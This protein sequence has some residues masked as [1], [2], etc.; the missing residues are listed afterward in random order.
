MTVPNIETRPEVILRGK[1]ENELISLSVDALVKT[2]P[3]ATQGQS[4]YIPV[5][6]HDDE[7]RTPQK[8]LLELFALIISE[9][10]G[11]EPTIGL[12]CHNK[13]KPTTIRL[14]PGLRI[15]RNH[16]VRAAGLIGERRDRTSAS[17][18]QAAFWVVGACRVDV[19]IDDLEAALALGVAV[20]GVP[21]P[22]AE[23]NVADFGEEK[24]FPVA[25]QRQARLAFAT[26]LIG[27]R[28][29]LPLGVAE[30]DGTELARVPVV[31]AEDLFAV[32][33]CLDKQFVGG[34]W[35]GR[36][37][38]T[39]R[40]PMI[41]DTRAD[42]MPWSETAI[43][44]V[45]GGDLIRRP[46]PMPGQELIEPGCRM[47]SDAGEHVGEPGLRVDAVELGGGDQGVDR[48]RPL[49]TAVAAGEQ[50]RAAPECNPAQRAL[51]SVIAQAKAAVFEKA[52]EGR[53][54]LEHVIHRF[55]DLGMARE[56]GAFGAHPCFQVADQRL[57]R[58]W[59]TARRFSGA[60]PLI[61]RSVA[62]IWSMRRTASTASG[63]FRRSASSKNLRRP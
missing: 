23:L 33:H 7:I 41:N 22:V 5:L 56:P 24:A 25:S 30:D 3:S 15:A 29:F 20:A 51:S 4:H 2:K 17:G 9:L 6:F 40:T 58:C 50:P 63:A 55:G 34:A 21:G 46:F 48:R 39:D 42:A 60:A 45:S 38:L 28:F 52:G 27:Q 12:V 43:A 31:G 11:T 53:P 61:S 59:R 8:I 16:P 35:H 10:Q 13:G 62:K 1:F 49:A 44:T 57:T 32:G 37:S 19:D 14:T 18:S 47:V 54:A 36:S 26:K